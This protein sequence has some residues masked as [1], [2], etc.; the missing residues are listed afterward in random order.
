VRW[1]S[2]QVLRHVSAS[3]QT[4]V[5]AFGFEEHLMPNPTRTRFIL[6]A[7]FTAN[8]LSDTDKCSTG[9]YT[10]LSYNEFRRSL[11]T[12]LFGVGPRRSVNFI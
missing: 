7:I 4:G 12:F 3:K 8:H 1:L 2:V 5:R 9:K 11:K 10:D 6:E